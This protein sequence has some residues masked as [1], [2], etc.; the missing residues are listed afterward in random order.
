VRRARDAGKCPYGAARRL[1][2]EVHEG[3]EVGLVLQPITIRFRPA[4]FAA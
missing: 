1:R 2:E 3:N 4:S